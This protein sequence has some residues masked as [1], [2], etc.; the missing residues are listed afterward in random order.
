MEQAV[1]GFVDDPRGAVREAESVLDEAAKQLT[2]KLEEQR[3]SLRDSWHGDKESDGDTEE[4][5]VALTHYR[6]MTRKLLD[7]A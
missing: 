1:G 2:R 6:D 3:K 4:L 5:R 7:F